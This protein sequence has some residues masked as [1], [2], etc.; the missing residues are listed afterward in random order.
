M[1]HSEGEAIQTSKG[2]ASAFVSHVTVGFCRAVQQNYE[3][4]DNGGAT[5]Q[6][7]KGMRARALEP[8]KTYTLQRY[9]IEQKAAS[10]L[11]QLLLLRGNAQ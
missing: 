2:G 8:A 9:C 10:P 3:M 5:P 6:Y 7:D 11:M 4:A 1:A